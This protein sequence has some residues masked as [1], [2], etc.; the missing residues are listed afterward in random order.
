MINWRK[1]IRT[2]VKLVGLGALIYL[3]AAAGYSRGYVDGSNSPVNAASQVTI[4]QIMRWG[5]INKAINFLE[6]DLDTNLVYQWSLKTDDRSVLDVMG[7]GVY[8]KRFMERISNYRR[9]VPYVN[10][11]PEIQK[12]ISAVLRQYSSSNRNN[13]LN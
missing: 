12:A 13:G 10:S 1:T 3:S 2:A 5:D 9:H 4:L 7:L 8:N 11:H 6:Q